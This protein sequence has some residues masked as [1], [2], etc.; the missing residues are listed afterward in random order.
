MPVCSLPQMED[1]RP[2]GE[3]SYRFL[4][5]GGGYDENLFRDQKVWEKID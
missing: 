4:Q 1:R 3:C 5:R 2:N